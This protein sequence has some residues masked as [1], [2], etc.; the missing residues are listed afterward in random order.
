V[1]K[2]KG[3]VIYTKA[4]RIK[5]WGHLDRRE[6]IKRVKKITDRNSSGIRTKG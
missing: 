4:Q 5:W 3:I 6:G 2:G 1:I